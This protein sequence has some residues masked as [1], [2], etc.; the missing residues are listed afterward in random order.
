MH[1]ERDITPARSRTRKL[2]SFEF[3]LSSKNLHINSVHDQQMLSK[4]WFW[5][6][7][8]NRKFFACIRKKSKD[9][10]DVWMFASVFTVGVFVYHVSASCYENVESF[11]KQTQKYG[12]WGFSYCFFCTFYF[13][14]GF[15]WLPRCVVYKKLTSNRC[16][17]LINIPGI[18]LITMWECTDI[19]QSPMNHKEQLFTICF[20]FVPRLDVECAI[21]LST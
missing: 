14:E 3:P 13:Y 15:Y 2:F 11:A 6:V 20:T 8:E 17:K 21:D 19:T 7:S 10:R 1:G 9:I 5:A 16:T 12:K 4:Y 18:S